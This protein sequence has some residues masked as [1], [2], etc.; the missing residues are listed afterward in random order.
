MN[1]GPLVGRGALPAASALVLFMV[2]PFASAWAG[3]IW[4]RGDSTG[5]CNIVAAPVGTARILYTPWPGDEAS[6]IVFRITGLP[7]SYSVTATP[8][9]IA[10]SVVGD[11]FGDGCTI[12]FADCQVAD[13]IVL[14][15]VQFED[16]TGEREA[17]L[18][19]V[20]GPLPGPPS[21]AHFWMCDGSTD[22]LRRCISG[23]QAGGINS[24]T[25]IPLPR[26]P[27]PADGAIDVPRDLRQVT[28][29]RDPLPL[30]LY[31][32]ASTGSQ[33][34]FGTT[35]DPPPSCSDCLSHGLL[36]ENTTY[37]WRVD[38]SW[39]G[40]TV[41]GPL[42]HFTTGT[43]VAIAKTSWGCIKTLYR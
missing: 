39:A 19:E 27:I 8:N 23:T 43:Y 4:F 11:P 22:P 28:W 13:E 25:E 7:N 35:P 24:S 17:A 9:P 20:W 29:E 6:K 1:R 2:V 18:L 16:L 33:I 37:Y 14:F 42:W 10:E 41:R 12:V 36:L 26:D 32:G 21:C 34:F 31:C 38:T 30:I 40:Q 5:N 3:Y 15:D